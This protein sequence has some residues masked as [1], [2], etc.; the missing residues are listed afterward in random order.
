MIQLK[1]PGIDLTGMCLQL[2][3]GHKMGRVVVQMQAVNS[4]LK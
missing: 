1:I 3:R 4:I 2:A